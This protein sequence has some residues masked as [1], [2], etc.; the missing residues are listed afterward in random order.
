[1]I[2]ITILALFLT[3]SLQAKDIKINKPYKYDST[4]E[5]AIDYLMID[6]YKMYDRD[7]VGIEFLRRNGQNDLYAYEIEVD[8]VDH[9]G[10]IEVRR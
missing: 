9:K 10:Q 1:M 6:E 3:I 4:Q 5:A 7:Y 2:K 8:G